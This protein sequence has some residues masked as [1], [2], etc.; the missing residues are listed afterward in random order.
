MRSGKCGL[1][2]GTWK[3]ML[4]DS[5]QQGLFLSNRGMQGKGRTCLSD[6]KGVVRED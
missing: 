2:S 6:V 1:S 5:V 4:R 3:G